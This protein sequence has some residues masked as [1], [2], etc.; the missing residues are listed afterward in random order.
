VIDRSSVERWLHSYQAAWRAPGTEGL[1]A[2]FTTDATYLHSP[3]AEPVTGLPAIA[4]MWEAD[5]AGP[6]EVFSLST[7]IVAVDADAA[8]VRALVRYGLPVRQEYTDLWVLRFDDRGRCSWFE[9]WPYWPGRG[10]SAR[11]PDA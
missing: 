8:V 4:A 7:D 5:R 10:W 1:G 6:D 9:E 2:V 11:D 3:Y